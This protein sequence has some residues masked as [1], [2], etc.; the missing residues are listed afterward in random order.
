MNTSPGTY[1]ILLKNV[2]HR[3]IRVFGVK[4][5]CFN[6]GYYLYIGSAFG[7]GGLRA[8]IGRHC[9]RQKVKRWHIDYLREAA[10][11]SRIWL[12]ASEAGRE[13]DWAK[14]LYG[15]EGFEP[16]TGFGCSDCRCRAH[17][18]FSSRRPRDGLMKTLLEGDIACYTAEDFTV[19]GKA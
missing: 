16:I 3:N 17:L 10:D 11:I 7:P 2:S 19:P 6:K 8:R 5:L 18:F 15:A 14:A 12:E 1:A 13:H 4:T 9:R